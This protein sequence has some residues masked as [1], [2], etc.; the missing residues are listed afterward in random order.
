VYVAFA[1][2]CCDRE[3]IGFRAAT[4]H[5]T[6]ETIRDLM[7]VSIEARF[8][9]GAL[10]VPH[11]VEWLSD[12]GPP[13]VAQATR[14]FGAMAGLLVVNTPESNGMAEAFVKTFKRDYVYL[15]RLPDAATVLANLPAWMDDYN[16]VR[17]HSRLG[18]LSP[19]A[20]RRSRRT[21]A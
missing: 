6:G 20:W 16:E 7:A 1:L 5:P 4:A 2:D 12:N 18:M 15:N 9:P 13:F 3:V 21:A 10:E 17:P 8:G 19:R 11:R 14:N